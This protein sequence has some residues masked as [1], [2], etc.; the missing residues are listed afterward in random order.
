MT[1]VS[2]LASHQHRAWRGH[3]FDCMDQDW[4]ALIRIRN[5]HVEDRPQWSQP[6]GPGDEP[7]WQLGKNDVW[8]KTLQLTEALGL[9]Q[10][11][12]SMHL[13]ALCFC[14]QAVKVN[15]P[16][17]VQGAVPALCRNTCFSAVIQ[18]YQDRAQLHYHCRWE[19]GSL[20]Q[21]SAQT[22]LMPTPWALENDCKACTPFKKGYSVNLAGQQRYVSVWTT[23][24]QHQHHCTALLPT[25]APPDR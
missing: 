8:L 17:P 25:S 12:E 5:H 9:S 13:R 21:C 16:P 4:F 2:Q 7:L 15:I 11:T 23:S 20:L 22:V 19:V 18:G 24:T 1:E 3:V 10:S 14:V 6:S